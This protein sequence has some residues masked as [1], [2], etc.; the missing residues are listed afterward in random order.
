MNTSQWDRPVEDGGGQGQNVEKVWD[1]QDRL[2]AY[3]ALQG[4]L[5]ILPL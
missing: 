2:R 5:G 3:I 4:S 1:D